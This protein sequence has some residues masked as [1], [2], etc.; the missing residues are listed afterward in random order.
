MPRVTRLIAATTLVASSLTARAIAA[1]EPAHNADHAESIGT[2]HFPTTCAPA[3]AA[4]MDRA[5]A[6]LHS[7]EFGA[8]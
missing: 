7:F 5:M 1:Q 8:T 6:L 3:V 2:V 4:R